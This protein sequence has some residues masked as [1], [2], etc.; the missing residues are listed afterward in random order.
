VTSTQ[1]ERARRRRSDAVEVVRERGASALKHVS[2]AIAAT[3]ARVREASRTVQTVPDSTL[4]WLAA[5]SIGLGAGL[6]LARAPRVV[7]AAGVAPALV[8]AAAI[9][10]RQDPIA[11]E[12]PAG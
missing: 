4:R 9:V 10:A 5:S 1:I 2:G 11:T 6:F 8:A 12:A 3:L 7:V